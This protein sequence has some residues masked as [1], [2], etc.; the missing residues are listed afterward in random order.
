MGGIIVIDVLEVIFSWFIGIISQ[1]IIVII[2]L[3]FILTLTLLYISYM[4]FHPYELT[5]LGKELTK[6][7]K[8][9]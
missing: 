2:A 8:G 4:I 3:V 1:I 7:I 6:I 5:T 9:K